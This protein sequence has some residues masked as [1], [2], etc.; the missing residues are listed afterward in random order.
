MKIQKENLEPIIIKLNFNL[1]ECKSHALEKFYIKLIGRSDLN[2]GPLTNLTDGG[3]G[4]T[5]WSDEQR[6]AQSDRMK[7]RFSNKSELEKHKKK[8]KDFWTEEKRK[9][10]SQKM[11]G[12]P[13][14]NK[15]KK[16][17]WVAWNKGLKGELNHNY[18]KK[19][20]KSV[21][22]KMVETRRNNGSFTFSEEH[23]KNISKSKQGKHKGGDNPRAKKVMVNGNIYGCIKDAVDK[24]NLSKHLIH[25]FITEGKDGFKYI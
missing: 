15:G 3:D 23:C 6:K 12:R 14:T 4:R 20:D 19:R 13:G 25:K 10:A 8:V 24:E 5:N 1:K 2:L 21:G 16:G 11:K 17:K 9:E 18:G 22:M 7:K